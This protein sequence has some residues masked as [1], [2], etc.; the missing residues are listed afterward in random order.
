[1]SPNP[2]P[3]QVQN[4][5]SQAWCIFRNIV[6]AVYREIRHIGSDDD[7]KARFKIHDADFLRA[8]RKCSHERSTL[9]T[10]QL[11]EQAQQA[12]T[13][14]GILQYYIDVTGLQLADLVIL[15]ERPGWTPKYGGKPWSVIAGAAQE[16]ANALRTND[17]ESV[18][19][20]CARILTL[21]HNNGPLVPTKEVGQAESYQQQKWPKLCD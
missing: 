4:S 12:N 13:V 3:A 16:L 19:F 9:Q 1:M 7:S 10:T 2:S 17:Q 5:T 21:H 14:D 15:Y 6:H 18:E 20:V 11:F 8:A